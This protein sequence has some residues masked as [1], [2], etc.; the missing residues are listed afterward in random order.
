MLLKTFVSANFYSHIK[1][2]LSNVKTCKNETN[3]LSHDEKWARTC[4]FF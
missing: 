4:C 2:K 3:T 1:M